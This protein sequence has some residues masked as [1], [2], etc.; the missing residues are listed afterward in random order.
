MRTRHIWRTASCMGFKMSEVENR[1][2]WG[3]QMSYSK[4]IVVKPKNV[5]FTLRT[6]GIHWKIKM[7]ILETSLQQQHGGGI[8]KKNRTGR[9]KMSSSATPLQEK[10]QSINIC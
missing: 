4:I 10:R 6:M 5:I 3:S 7:C 1:M 8:W 9:K 2:R